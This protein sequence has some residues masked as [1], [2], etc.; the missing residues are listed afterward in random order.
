MTKENKIKSECPNCRNSD[1]VKVGFRKN[2]SGKK[3]KYR[4]NDCSKYFVI[5]DG[6]KGAHFTPEIITRAIH[7]YSDCASLSKTQNHLYQHDSV[8][9][10]DVSILRW[11]RRYAWILKKRSR[12]FAN[13]L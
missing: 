1:V 13:Q 4:C 10:S 7:E 9:V 2:K 11:V 6:F 12:S 5:D 3:Q 8:K